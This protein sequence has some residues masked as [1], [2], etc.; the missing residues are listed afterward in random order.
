MCIL[1]TQHPC[2][3]VACWLR[4]LLEKDLPRARSWRA[5]LAL[6]PGKFAP[7][8]EVGDARVR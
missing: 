1:D 7:H 5:P 8:A 6:A 2:T 4:A 3:S